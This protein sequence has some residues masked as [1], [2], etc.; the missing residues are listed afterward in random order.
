MNR[1]KG[2]NFEREMCKLL[3]RW[4]TDKERDDIFWRT[5]QSGGRATQR[6]KGGKSTYGSY[7]DIAAVDPIGAPLLKA[8][9]IELK[10]G[11]SHGNPVDLFDAPRTDKIRGWEHCLDQTVRSAKDAQSIGWLLI[12]QR[13]RRL[14]C[15]SIDFVS[16]KKLLLLS[17]LPNIRFHVNVN[18]LGILR[19]VSMPLRVFL[20]HVKPKHVVQYLAD[21]GVDVK[22]YGR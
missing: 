19:Y 6:A 20:K 1:Q 12:L 21:S 10:R 13:D 9:T 16:A 17:V 11:N 2:S 18:G 5:S 8:F 4:W 15:I 22:K 7:G 3:S 14:P